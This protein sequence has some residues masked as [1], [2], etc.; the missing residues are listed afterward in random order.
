MKNKN[1]VLQKINIRRSFIIPTSYFS[2][3]DEGGKT[4]IKTP[5]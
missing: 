4:N 2:L 5:T 3:K 1:K